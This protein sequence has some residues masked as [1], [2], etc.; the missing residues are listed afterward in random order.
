M[1]ENMDQRKLTELVTGDKAWV[2]FFRP[3]RK[4]KTSLGWKKNMKR[5]KIA[6]RALTS[7]KVLCAIFFNSNGLVTQHPVPK[8]R[9]VTSNLYTKDI[10]PRLLK[11]YKKKAPKDWF[12]GHKVVT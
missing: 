4:K 12:Q 8:G 7:K 3:K 9:S 5:P 11:Y 6:R 2:H 1:F 10:L